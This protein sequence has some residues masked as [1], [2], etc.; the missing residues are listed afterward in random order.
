MKQ[1]ESLLAACQKLTFTLL[2]FVLAMQSTPAFA[3]NATSSISQSTNQQQTAESTQDHAYKD[4][5]L[6]ISNAII[7]KVTQI[8]AKQKQLDAE[9]YPA[10]KPPIQAELDDLKK[11]LEDLKLRKTQLEAQ[12]AATDAASSAK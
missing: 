12:K 11:Q 8:Q 1:E 4:E 6:K 10:Y 7:Q 3:D 2:G 9:I 5:M